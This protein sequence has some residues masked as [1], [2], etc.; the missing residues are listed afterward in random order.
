[1]LTIGKCSNCGKV[2]SPSNKDVIVENKMARDVIKCPSC[3][4]EL[5]RCMS[6]GCNNY[7]LC[8]NVF[9][10]L[11]CS[12]C[13]KNVGDA[14]EKT[15]D[16]VKVCAEILVKGVEVIIKIQTLKDGESS[17]QNKKGRQT[18]TTKKKTSPN[19]GAKSSNKK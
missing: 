12:D 1:M 9:D 19:K 10:N 2:I 4:F 15:A 6:P 5:V 8:G 14:I 7:A 13:L 16:I 11:V 17:G 3:G 18:S